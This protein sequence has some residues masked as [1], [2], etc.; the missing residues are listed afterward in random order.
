ML[1]LNGKPAARDEPVGRGGNREIN[2]RE[3]REREMGD[4]LRSVY[5]TAVQEQVPDEF[6][7]LLNKLD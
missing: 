6:L 2:G 3:V 7:D 4:A 1:N 5:D